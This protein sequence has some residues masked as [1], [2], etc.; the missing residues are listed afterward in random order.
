MTKEETIEKGRQASSL[1][2][3]MKPFA[4][5]YVSAL[6]EQWLLEQNAERREALWHKLNGFSAFKQKLLVFVQNGES[7][8]REV[9][10]M[11]G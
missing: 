9:E 6:K 5:E 10:K 7:A 2:E 1:L 3:A 4:D 8:F 11:N